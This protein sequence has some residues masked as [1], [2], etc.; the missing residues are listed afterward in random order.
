MGFILGW[1]VNGARL[2]CF[3]VARQTCVGLKTITLCFAKTPSGL[4]F[5]QLHQAARRSQR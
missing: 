1:K 5:Q 4:Y 3:V 2:R